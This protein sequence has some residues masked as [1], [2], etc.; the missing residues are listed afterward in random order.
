MTVQNHMKQALEVWHLLTETTQLK[1]LFLH[2]N[3]MEL[4]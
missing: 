4:K 3:V 2:K 1:Q